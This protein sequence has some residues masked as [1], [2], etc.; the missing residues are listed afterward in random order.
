M[1]LPPQWAAKTA[2]LPPRLKSQ[3]KQSEWAAKT[4]SDLQGMILTLILMPPWSDV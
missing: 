1:L 4:W 2:L 3:E